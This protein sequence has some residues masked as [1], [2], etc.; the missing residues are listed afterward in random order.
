MRTI[1]VVDDSPTMRKMVRAALGSLTDVGFIEA[2]SGL[3]AIETLA[4]HPAL[5][6]TDPGGTIGVRLA[7][8]GRFVR[9]VVTDTGHGISPEFL[10]HVFERFRQADASSSRRHGGLGVGLALVHDLIELHGG[11]VHAHSEGE[12]KGAEL[13]PNVIVSD[14]GMPTEDGYQLMRRTGH[15]TQSSAESP[16]SR[17]PDTRHPKTC[18]APSMQDSNCTSPSPWTLLPSS[19]PWRS[20]RERS[21]CRV[22]FLFV[23][24]WHCHG[25]FVPRFAMRVTCGVG[26]LTSPESTEQ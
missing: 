20:W 21:P 8:N 10:P 3:Q 7:L 9:I 11:S 22:P 15:S 6:F 26:A 23:A 25:G 2:S 14:L 13:L 17:S 1:L 24:R 18:N 19:E 4:I 12:G 16:P 5:K